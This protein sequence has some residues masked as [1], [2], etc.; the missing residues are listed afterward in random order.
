MQMSIGSLTWPV[1][2]LGQQKRSQTGL[3]WVG[4]F[5]LGLT[6]EPLGPLII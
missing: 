1:G 2:E 3:L 5:S 4:V 6:L